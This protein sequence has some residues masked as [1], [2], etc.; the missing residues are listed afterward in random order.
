M[1]NRDREMRRIWNRADVDYKEEFKGE[2]VVIQAHGYIVRG[3]RWTVDFL[4][5]PTS[6]N[7][8]FPDDP[9]NV[10]NLTWELDKEGDVPE[11][12]PYTCNICGEIF[13]TKQ[14]LGGHMS[15]NHKRQPAAPVPA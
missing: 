4:G 10:K 8:E 9:N 15:A 6:F 11:I 1:A 3:R 2:D 12:K 14:S 13:A 7:P 5:S